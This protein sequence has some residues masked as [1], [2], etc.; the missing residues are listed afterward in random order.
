MRPREEFLPLENLKLHVRNAQ[1]RGAARQ[2][3]TVCLKSREQISGQRRTGGGVAGELDALGE[4]VFVADGDGEMVG[5]ADKLEVGEGDCE[6]LGD[7]VAEGEVDAL[8]SGD[9]LEDGEGDCDGV[10]D[11]DGADDTDGDVDSEGVREADGEADIDGAVDIDTETEG[12]DVTVGATEGSSL[13]SKGRLLVSEQLN[14]SSG[15]RPSRRRGLK[16]G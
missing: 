15:S 9:A 3:E 6:E 1:K 13:S 2:F 14:P 11:I 12:V 16:H 8:G 10:T 5:V 7:A 4:G